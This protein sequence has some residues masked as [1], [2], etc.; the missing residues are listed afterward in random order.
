MES[1]SPLPST[2]ING[3]SLQGKW[4]F[5]STNSEDRVRKKL[6]NK[7]EAAAADDDTEWSS[8][9]EYFSQSVNDASFL[10]G[11]S[12]TNLF[13]EKSPQLGAEVTI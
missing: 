6:F 2:P 11:D 8:S 5:Q 4:T 1:P 13:P 12:H 9:S 7:L 10:S 3:L